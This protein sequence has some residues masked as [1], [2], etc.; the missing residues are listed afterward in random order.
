MIAHTPKADFSYENATSTLTSLE[1]LQLVE[2]AQENIN[3]SQ[4][5][6]T[7]I[8][9]LDETLVHSSFTRPDRYDIDLIVEFNCTKYKVYVQIRPGAEDFLK[10]VCLRYDVYIFTASM[11][12]YSIPVVSAIFPWFDRSHILSRNHCRVYRSVFVKD[13]TI[14]QKCLSRVI[15]VDNSAESFCL[16]P[17]NGILISTWIGDENDNALNGELLPFLS[18]CSE[19][20]D[21]R[22]VISSTYSR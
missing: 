4:N 19:C 9:D 8:L 3:S 22:K 18:M 17:Q 6:I 2:S 16:Q 1:A 13:I 12:E 11:A 14:F 10:A 7:L 5:R 21:V 15:I 20:D